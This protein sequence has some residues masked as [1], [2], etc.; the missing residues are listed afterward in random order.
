MGK[1]RGAAQLVMHTNGEGLVIS[2][3]RKAFRSLVAVDDL[4]FEVPRGSMFGL[5]GANGAG[6]T[7]TLRMVLNIL[8]PDAG[9]ITWNG[10][11]A[12]RVPRESFGYLPEERGLYPKMK[13][14][15]Q[16]VFL[17]S[18]NNLSTA[19]ATRRAREWL[20]NVGLEHEWNRKVEELS[21]GNQ[22]KVQVLAAIL[23]DPD[24]MLLDQPV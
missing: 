17:A 6:K 21:K 14:G 15:E 5:L 18:L 3:V 8:T 23:H 12:A 24:L 20:Q 10:V 7:T 13:T 2:H 19:E 4:T 11:D 16:L 22:Q 9:A 1:S